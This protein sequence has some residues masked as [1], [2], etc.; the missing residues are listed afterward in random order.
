VSND[1]RREG[2]SWSDV[3]LDAQSLTVFRKKQQWDESS[4]PAPVIHPLRIYKRVLDPPTDEWP[5]F[6]TFHYPTLGHL[7][8]DGLAAQGY[9]ESDIADIR[10]EHE[11]DLLLCR[12][13]ALGLPPSITTH[14]A[15]SRMKRLCADAG[16]ELDDRMGISL[17][18]A[19]V[20]GWVRSS[21]GS[22]G[23][24]PLRAISITQSRW[25]ANAIRT[26]RR[27]NRPRWR[28][29]P[30]LQPTSGFVA[31]LKMSENA[32]ADSIPVFLRKQVIDMKVVQTPPSSSR[33]RSVGVTVTH[34]DVGCS[35]A[36]P[37]QLSR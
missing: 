17:R 21:S 13:Y 26:S 36:G 18:M 33:P 34:L 25:S 7:V 22:S 12:E 31:L 23:T 29:K 1:E 30:L 35:R 11:R 4:I 37:Q 14:A 9:A 27:A 10:D 19:V 2:L 32:T 20:V 3:D 16:I 15:R 8:R 5:V 24:R 6:P 28:P